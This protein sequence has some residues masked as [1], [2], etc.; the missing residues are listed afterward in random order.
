MVKFNKDNIENIIW[1]LS[2]N[3]ESN[4]READHEI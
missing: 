1:D 4:F 2:V 3:L